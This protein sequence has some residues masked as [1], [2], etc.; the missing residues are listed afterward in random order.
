LHRELEQTAVA[1]THAL[2]EALRPDLMGAFVE[3]AGG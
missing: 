2:L 3:W 1:A